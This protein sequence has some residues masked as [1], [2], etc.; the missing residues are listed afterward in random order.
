MRVGYSPLYYELLKLPFKILQYIAIFGI[1]L[2]E[3]GSANRVPGTS[4]ETQNMGNL[5]A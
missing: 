5:G 3:R 2:A 4:Y 1:I